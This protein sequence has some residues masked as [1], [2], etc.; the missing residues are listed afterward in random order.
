MRPLVERLR[1]IVERGD[2]IGS[3]NLAMMAEAA[4][5]LESSLSK[6]EAMTKFRDECERQFQA[7]VDEVGSLESRLDQCSKLADQWAALTPEDCSFQ[8]EDGR[9]DCASMRSA[10]RQLS[11][12][13]SGAATVV[14]SSRGCAGGSAAECA[15]ESSGPHAPE[16]SDASASH[17]SSFVVEKRVSNVAEQCGKQVVEV[18]GGKQWHCALPKDHVGACEQQWRKFDT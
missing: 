17:S 18:Q 8:G 4:D 6:L 13:L 3:R 2:D 11:Q 16:A 12:I 1:Q 9:A 7:K 5:E 15:G 10:G 14:E